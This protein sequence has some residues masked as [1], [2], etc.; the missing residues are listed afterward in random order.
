MTT[1]PKN[2]M[3]YIGNLDLSRG[4]EVMS[5]LAFDMKTTIVLAGN[6]T[7]D[8]LE[9]INNNQYMDYRGYLDQKNISE[10]M[11][12]SKIGLILHDQSGNH[13]YGFPTKLFEYMQHSLPVIVSRN[14]YTSKI[15]NQSQCGYAVDIDSYEELVQK[16]KSVYF[17]KKL[18][19]KLSLYALNASKKYSWDSEAK[20]LINLYNELL[21]N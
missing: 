8:S 20:K 12:N 14:Y 15:V 21:L 1:S 5:R 18:H 9:I 4:I 3:C 11:F 19:E 2:Q 13:K 17:N 16:V 10:I 6:A 7:A